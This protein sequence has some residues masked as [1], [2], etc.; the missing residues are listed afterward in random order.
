M[1]K[2]LILLMFIANTV[3]AQNNITW[4]RIST[5]TILN[6]NPFSTT[7]TIKTGYYNINPKNG[8]QNRW[9][10]TNWVV[11]SVFR[12]QTVNTTTN[13]T[14]TIYGAGSDFTPEQYGAIN[15]NLT[16]SQ[17]GISQDTINIKYPGIGATINDNIDWAAW[18]MAIRQACLIGGGVSEGRNLLSWVK[19]FNSREDF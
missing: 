3:T 10:G 14:N 6:P 7:N 18:Q 15:A 9:A 12:S 2:L 19:I 4:Y 8:I 5:D 13:I 11:D 16:F 1:K 17:K